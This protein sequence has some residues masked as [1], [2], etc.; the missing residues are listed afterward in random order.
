MAFS[1]KVLDSFSKLLGIENI[2]PNDLYAGFSCL[3]VYATIKTNPKTNKKYK[4]YS[5]EKL[6]QIWWMLQD[7]SST[8][9]EDV[10]RIIRKNRERLGKPMNENKETKKIFITEEQ[11]KYINSHNSKPFYVNPEQVNIVKKYLDT[12]FKRGS[13]HT[14]SDEGYPKETKI[15]AMIG[16]DGNVLRNMTDV[17][18]FYLLQDRFQHMFADMENRDKF[19]KQIIKDWYNK[20]ISNTGLLS[21]NL[22]K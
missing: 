19:L 6:R 8:E 3:P 4:F 18:L 11:A 5:L 7:P 9:R 10:I 15:V 17:Q 16:T 12:G 13:M 2:T 20:K 14:I 21:V 22:I 1:K